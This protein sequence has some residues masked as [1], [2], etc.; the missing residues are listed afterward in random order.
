MKTR[1]NLTKST[2]FFFILKGC[3]PTITYSVLQPHYMTEALLL[4]G[5]L[6]YCEGSYRDAVSMYAKSGFDHQSLDNEP[7]YKMRLFAEAFVIKGKTCET[8]YYMYS[9]H[10][11]YL[12]LK[13]VADVR[14]IEQ[15]HPHHVIHVAEVV[16]YLLYCK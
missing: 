8:L 11:N 7:L 9:W 13:F 15:L 5:K 12:L 6:H 16:L 1:I 3:L 14:F 4:L 2:C 10:Q